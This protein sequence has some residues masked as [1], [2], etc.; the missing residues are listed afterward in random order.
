M[1][2]NF[3][4]A[5]LFNWYTQLGD[6]ACTIKIY[7]TVSPGTRYSRKR[8]RFIKNFKTDGFFEGDGGGGWAVGVFLSQA[9]ENKELTC[10]ILL[11]I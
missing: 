11:R 6:F 5:K 7:Q 2:C 3:P 4:I 1:I 9:S 8:S 10:G